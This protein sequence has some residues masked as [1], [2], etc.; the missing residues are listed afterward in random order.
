MNGADTIQI[1]PMQGNDVPACARIM[2]GNEL[3]Q[4][5]GIT[6]EAA[7]ARF[8]KAL[9][10]NAS[11]LVATSG[12]QT[13][14]FCW[15]H[16]KGAF[17]RSGYIQLIGIDPDCKGQGIGKLLLL[18][19]E[20]IVVQVSDDM[21]LTVSDFNASAQAFYQKLGYDFVGEIPDYVQPG[22][23]EKIMRKKLAQPQ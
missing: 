14:G 21:F 11:I 16:R 9:A 18:S 3:W 22:I 2:A 19:A 8:E 4:R 13:V 23:A 7:I 20:E 15:Y 5:Y 12:E 10:D 1:R 6:P 17:N